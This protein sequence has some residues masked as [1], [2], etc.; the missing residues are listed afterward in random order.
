MLN[1]YYA[2]VLCFKCFIRANRNKPIHETLLTKIFNDVH[3]LGI[4]VR[5]IVVKTLATHLYYYIYRV[6]FL[7]I[8]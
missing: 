7:G 5:S 3:I 4:I 2:Y 1:I 8:L 6:I